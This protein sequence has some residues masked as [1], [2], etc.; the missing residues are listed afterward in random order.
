VF[1]DPPYDVE[2][3]EIE[4]MLAALTTRGWARSGTVAVGERPASGPSL[5]WPSGWEV[6]PERKYGDT[7]LEIAQLNT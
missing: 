3:A 6:W 1:A 5:R 2:A 7:R 4:E